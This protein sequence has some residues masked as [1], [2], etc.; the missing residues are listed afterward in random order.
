MTMVGGKP[1]RGFQV[2]A[3]IVSGH[4]TVSRR[5]GEGANLDELLP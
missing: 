4:M 5:S 1:F 3:L 2:T